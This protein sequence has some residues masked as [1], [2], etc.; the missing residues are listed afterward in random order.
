MKTRF[1]KRSISNTVRKKEYEFKITYNFETV[2]EQ[3]H[4][5]KTSFKNLLFSKS[6]LV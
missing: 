6:S 2:K 1:N 5:G 4:F 3:Q